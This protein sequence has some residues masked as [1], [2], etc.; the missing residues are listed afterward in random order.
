MSTFLIAESMEFYQV[1]TIRITQ[2]ILMVGIVDVSPIIQF[3]IL[4]RIVHIYPAIQLMLF[5]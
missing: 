3:R 5:R 2:V 1:L 4:V